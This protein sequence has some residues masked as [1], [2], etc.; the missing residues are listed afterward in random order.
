MS[1][2][3]EDA[4]S[5]NIEDDMCPLYN[6]KKFNKLSIILHWIWRVPQAKLQN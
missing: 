4:Y 3:I 5:F 1:F 6:F 2:N